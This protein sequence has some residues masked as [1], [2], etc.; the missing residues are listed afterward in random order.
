[1]RATVYIIINI[2]WCTKCLYYH[3]DDVVY[4]PLTW[5]LMG[6]SALELLKFASVSVIYVRLRCVDVRL[7]MKWRFTERVRHQM[8][9]FIYGFSEFIPPDLLK[10]FDE[11]EVEVCAA[12]FPLS[13]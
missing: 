10:I 3:L 2:V 8:A 9:A 13:Q 4:S 11:N 5:T 7:V 12:L 1:M 6:F